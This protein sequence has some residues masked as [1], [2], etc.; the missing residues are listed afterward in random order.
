MPLLGRA[1]LVV[2]LGLVA[3]AALAGAYAA[4]TGKRRLIESARNA[5]DDEVSG[6][7][8]SDVTR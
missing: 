8:P 7:E 5:L 4:Y 3:Y 6:G 1:A 2:A